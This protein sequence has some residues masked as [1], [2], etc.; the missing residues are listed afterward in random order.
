MSLAV[1]AQRTRESLRNA[2]AMARAESFKGAEEILAELLAIDEAALLDADPA[3]TIDMVD[4][5]GALMPS[6]LWEPLEALLR[7]SMRVLDRHAARRPLHHFVPRNNLAVLY[8][9]KGLRSK[10][11][12]LIGEMI[13]DAERLEGPVDDVTATIFSTFLMAYERAEH[14]PALRI[15]YRHLSLNA[16]ASP[17]AKTATRVVFTV[18]YCHALDRGGNPDAALEAATRAAALLEKDPGFTVHWRLQ[19]LEQMIDT[20]RRKRDWDRAQTL[21]EQAR[22]LLE[23]SE[24]KDSEDAQTVYH[25]LA[26]LYMYTK[27]RE[28]YEEAE[29]LLRRAR[30]IVN[31]LK[32][33]GSADYAAE[34]YQ[35]GTVLESQ[36]EVER[37]LALYREAFALYERAP[38]TDPKEFATCL[39]SV[40]FTYLKRGDAAQAITL[41]RRALDLLAADGESPAL[42]EAFSNLSTAHFAKL[43][44]KPAI[45][46]YERAIELRSGSAR[47]TA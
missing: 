1:L 33:A 13:A 25:N 5:A 21:Y 23:G 3:V 6:R 17:E 4:A 44:F 38:D 31:R 16:F 43:D 40:A 35:I 9:S 2:N 41:F 18:R 10:A 47:T 20:A 12:T 45:E 34:T 42:A 30:D 46:L 19:L 22:D 7:K 11:S 32:G 37:A 27:K 28:R 14:W 26:A 29:R 36:G 39:S 8:E 24:L 15:L